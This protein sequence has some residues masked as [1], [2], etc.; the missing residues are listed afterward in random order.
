MST[1]EISKFGQTFQEIDGK[2][3]CTVPG[4]S[5]QFEWK[6]TPG[7]SALLWTNSDYDVLDDCQE[8]RFDDVTVAVD[9][10][11]QITT[12]PTD[13]EA[14]QDM[15]PEADRDTTGTFD[16]SE[17]DEKDDDLAGEI[18]AVKEG[19]TVIQVS[20]YVDTMGS[21]TPVISKAWANHGEVTIHSNGTLS[22]L[23]DE[24]GAARD[25]ITFIVHDSHWSTQ[26]M[27]I[28]IENQVPLTELGSQLIPNQFDGMD[29]HVSLDIGG[30]ISDLL[31]DDNVTISVTGLPPGLSY[32]A[33]RMHI[34]GVLN[35]DGGDGQTYIVHVSITAANGQVLSTQFRW[36]V[37]QERVLDAREALTRAVPPIASQ[38]EAAAAAVLFSVASQAAMSARGFSLTPNAIVNQANNA[39]TASQLDIARNDLLAGESARTTLTGN[40]GIN[41]ANLRLNTPVPREEEGDQEEQQLAEPVTNPPARS[42]GEQTSSRPAPR[43]SVELED[44][45]TTEAGS[46]AAAD[47]NE[48]PRAGT[49][50]TATTSEDTG[51]SGI[52]VL[53]SAF[54]P[55]GDALTLTSAS[56]NSGVV[57]VNPDGTL[58]YVPD[59]NFNGTDTVTYTIS[60][61]FGNTTG[62]TLTVIVTSVNDAPVAGTRAATVTNEDTLLSNID[63]LSVASDQDGDALTVSAAT[64]GNGIVSV[65]GDGTINYNPNADY[66]GT[67]TINYTISDGN[68]GSDSSSFTVTVNSVNDAPRP[69]ADSNIVVEDGSISINVLANDSDVDGTIDP[70]T[71]QIV[72]TASPGDPLVV[73]G[74]GTWTVNGATGDITFTPLA[75]YDGVV[76][77][78]SYTVADNLGARSA[79]ATISVSI[80]PVNDAPV[81]VANSS[82][83]AED[84]SVTINILANDTDIDNALNP[85]TVQ[86]VGTA[87]AGDPLTVPGEGLWTINPTTGEIT[88]TPEANYEGPVTD[89]SYTVQDAAGALSNPATV[90]VSITGSNDAP[91]AGAV[92][93]SATNEDT[94]VNNIDVLSFVTDPDGDPIT[95]VS[96]SAT[97]GNVTINPD[98]T[99]NY[100]PNTNYNGTDTIS[101]NVSDGSGGSASGSVD[102]V[103]AP[104]N[105]NP[106]AG[107]PPLGNGNEDAPVNNIDVLSYATDIDGDLLSVSAASAANGLVTIN[108]D[109]TLNYTPNANFNGLDTITYTVDDGNGGSATGSKFV[110]VNSVNDAPV[111][112]NESVSVPEDGAVTINVLTNDSDIDGSLVA[113]TIQITGT[114][115]AGDSLV[116][117]GEGTW[118]VNTTTG[119]ITFTAEADYTGLVTPITYT[120]EDNNGAVSNPATVSVTITSVNDAPVGSNDSGT[121][122][123][124]TSVTIDVLAN[125]N[126]IDGTL[127]PATVQ[128]TGTASAGDPLT[129]PGEGV[130]TVNSTTGEITFTPETDYAGPVTD[131]TYT[132][133]DN[134]GATSNATTVSVTITPV[135]DGPTANNDSDTVLEDGSV[136]I[137]I[138]ANDVD[139]DG[140]LVP[141]TVQI[142]GTASAGD[143]LTVPGEGVWTVN[144]TTGEITFTP[145][146]NYTGSVTDISYIVED[147][148]GVVSNPATVSV[149]ISA[150]NDIPVIDLSDYDNAASN[151][152]F[153][154]GSVGSWTDWVAVGPFTPFGV[155]PNAPA[156]NN[157][158]VGAIST[159]T[160]TGVTGLSDGPGSNGAALIQFDLG[161]NNT[162]GDGG[163]AQELTLSVGGVD[164]VTLTTPAGTGATT[165]VNFLNGASGTPATISASTYLDW[166]YTTID[167]NLP[168]AVAD[169]ADIQFA[170]EN[171][172]GPEAAT[173]DISI[174]NVK[175]IVN[176]TNPADADHQVDYQNGN[177]PI[178]LLDSSASIQDIDGTTLQS[179]RVLLTF[180]ESGDA[181]RVGGVPATNGASGTVGGLSWSSTI[182]GGQIEVNLTGS[183][184]HAAY[185]AALQQIQFESNSA[186][187]VSSTRVVDITVN[188]G[189]SDSV[190]AQTFILFDIN[191][192]PPN[193]TDDVASGFEDVALVI[194]VLANDTNGDF[195]IDPTTVHIRGTT[196][197]GDSLVIAGEGTWSVNGVTGE[198]TF[199]PEAEYVG[200]PTPIEYT[201]S[202]TSGLGSKL[203]QVSA[204]ISAVNDVP[205]TVA[206]SGVVT[207]DSSVV[208]DVL[209]NDSDIDG[210]LVPSTVQIT[211]TTNPGDSLVVAG[212]GTWSVNTTTG[213]ITF[214]PEADFAG[215][216]TDITYTVDDN[217]GGTSLPA[218]VSATI[219]PVNDAPNTS[220]DSDTVSEDSAVVI[221]VL[222]NDVDIDGTLVPST[223]QIVGTT[224]PGDPLVVGGEG[225]WTVNSTTGAITFTPET[226]YT[227][228]VTDI[229]YTVDDNSGATSSPAT[230]SVTI[231]GV[232]DAPTANN[233]SDTVT[234]DDTVAIDVLANDTDLD[235]T[236]VPSTVQIV[237][238]AAPGNPLIV[239][240]QGT[241]TVNTTTGAIS[242]TPEA[243]YTGAVTPISYTVQDDG[244]A[245]SS[246]ATVSVTITAVNDAPTTSADADTVVED[247]AVIIDVLAND[248]DIDGTLDPATVQIVGTTN[249]GDSLVVGGEGTWSVNTTTGAITFTPEPNFDG[250]VTNISYTV[251]DNN[252]ATSSPTIVAVSILGV[253]DQPLLDLDSGTGGND[254]S[255]SYTEGAPGVSIT[256]AN[257]VPNDPENAIYSITVSVGA[258]PDGSDE[259]II[260][261][262]PAFEITSDNSG[263]TTLG[264][265]LQLAYTYT[266]ATRELVLTNQAGPGNAMTNAQVEEA[267][268]SLRY[269][270]DSDDPTTTDRTFSVVLEDMSGATSL[271]ADAVVSVNAV[272]DAP[273]AGAN[274]GSV[275]EDGSVA[276]NVLSNDAD[277]DGTLD[278]ASIQIVGTASAGD[279]LVVVGEGTWTVDTI[280]GR[281]SFTPEANYSG[282]VTPISYTVR[283]NLGA[284][285]NP[286]TVTMTITPVN[287]APTDINVV[288]GLNLEARVP[289]STLSAT[290]TAVDE[291]GDTI[292]YSLTNDAGGLF[293]ID[294]ASG[295]ISISARGTGTMVLQSGVD[296][297]FEGVDYDN[298]SAP[299]FVDL[300]NDGDLDVLVGNGDEGDT[301]YSENVGSSETPSYAAFVTNPFGLDQ[302]SDDVTPA[303]VDIDNDGDF[304]VF[305]GSA[306]GEIRY[307]RNDGSDTS[308]SFTAVGLNQF[309]LTST[310]GGYSAPTFIDIDGDNDYD[311]FIGDASGNIYYQENTGT[312]SSPNFTAAVMNPFGLTDVGDDAKPNFVDYDGDGDYDVF[313]GTL[314]GDTYYFENTGTNLAPSF[315][316]AVVN[317]FGLSDIGSESAPSFGDIDSDGDLDAIIG[318]SNGEV[319]YFENQSTAVDHTMVT[320]HTITVEAQDT[321]ANTYSEDIDI[322]F[323]S[324]GGETI[325]GGANDDVLYGFGGTDTLEGG[326]GND[327]VDGGGGAAETDTYIANGAQ[328]DF[329]VVDNLD[330]TFTLT[331]IRGG[332]PQGTDTLLN[333]EQVQFTDATVSLGLNQTGTGGVDNM[334]GTSANDTLD[335]GNG[336]DVIVGGA[337]DDT[338]YGDGGDD[339]ITGGAGDDTIESGSGTNDIMIYS[340]NRADYIVHDN[341]GGIYLVIDTRPGSPDGTDTLITGG[342]PGDLQFADQ[343]VDV[344]A[345]VTSTSPIAFD[346]NR[347]GEINV[348]G[349]TT[350]KDKSGIESIGATVEFDM[351][352]DDDLETIEW[353]DGTGDALLVD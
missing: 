43:A 24:T 137:D 52:N 303:V 185:L 88:F 268:E 189:T 159:L 225:T 127:L 35:S 228:S 53:G 32:N 128:I 94:T 238:T 262:S 69:V 77:D 305:L 311:A 229:S 25:D 221:D 352:G 13:P 170:W 314:S 329:T 39:Q 151:S 247:G 154:A 306:G 148:D 118:S 38:N 104:V 266:A 279:P 165:S 353:L 155:A 86:I 172:A 212:E 173:D 110:F 193:S 240:G 265:G 338:I 233:D 299:V 286:A 167:L 334:T 121:L 180:A 160:Q 30:Y 68:G 164:Y 344:D 278:P 21:E 176:D 309:G 222:A 349:E 294:S 73:A 135:N 99:I 74:Q 328:A 310:P 107:S 178:S 117:A 62:G 89:I 191:D 313:V 37:Q 276:V 242:F 15:S 166:T 331:D 196:N 194:D 109:G 340:G 223:V 28:R 302:Y 295:A 93:D 75:D 315:A 241:W 142:V 58:D 188:D 308:P 3:V 213:A 98:G 6:L 243:D 16:H 156:V 208:I 270:N 236:L 271:S 339:T 81:A 227:G 66:F 125:D 251:D 282:S 26:V 214:T 204:T 260:V 190:A 280:L 291:V 23:P 274:G 186:S 36:I 337:G 17:T 150:T 216:V 181:F 348:T 44:E 206:D 91:V 85:A 312:I 245:T 230:V 197:P 49:G 133:Q 163:R 220:N 119:Q 317:P 115:S 57:G 248:S 316:A 183:G 63:V 105:D 321:G 59:P 152:S 252:G 140:S 153:S 287:D 259:Y 103:V 345:A 5:S 326:A 211:G 47:V 41:A 72:G 273:T 78:I 56:A 14:D 95:V 136:A 215:T 147:N 292:T 209:A 207:E 40:E 195:P 60:D 8:I 122:L 239:A 143:P 83:V 319:E 10:S 296:D 341:G 253:N 336:D 20:D 288:G 113:S 19:S 114:A 237:G 244:G 157:D 134:G 130:W 283:D 4:N 290:A 202:D 82:V 131:I 346:L 132:V 102:V 80:T 256:G 249:P 318:R 54:D 169:T 146:T 120:V 335:G 92:P 144:S 2:T 177:P 67:D 210:T 289:Y 199:T 246:S 97:N 347:D 342:D 7:S 1:G 255:A 277:V 79:P 304:D 201:V 70:T 45:A 192:A 158:A 269:R 50:I 258:V 64:A 261:N 343:T 351:D 234:E 184:S 235:G 168:A 29:T 65:N 31:M 275:T 232:N 200:T 106:N 34:E 18:T 71:V 139:V 174:D 330:G 281:I 101:F 263:F 175:V 149:S 205:I 27:K 141:S 11:G 298:F 55:D 250:S 300:D 179:A 87:S 267:L 162:S 257:T 116:V 182:S 231:T 51:L 96:A 254:S 217:S 264:S 9:D 126:D 111:A 272:N 293:E 350:A 12:T 332:S 324:D 301:L 33:G 322:R 84:S 333:I 226:D 307:R 112:N 161:W 327:Y 90:S 129:V 48:A 219:T 108:P 297:P 323:G 171:L 187:P 218:T 138:L 145:E 325:T 61:S 76:T 100:T 203:A 285:S 320:S 42:N 284:V 46:A 22:Y 224:N 123:E 124:D 198:I